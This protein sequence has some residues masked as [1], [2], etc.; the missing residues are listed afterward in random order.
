MKFE[1]KVTVTITSYSGKDAVK[2][3]SQNYVGKYNDFCE[4]VTDPLFSE[5]F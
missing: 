2:E 1:H 5:I 3:N 4:A